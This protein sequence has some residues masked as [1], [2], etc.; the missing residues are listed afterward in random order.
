MGLGMCRR[1]MSDS[2]GCMIERARDAL[3]A[4]LAHA[5]VTATSITPQRIEPRRNGEIYGFDVAVAGAEESALMFVDTSTPSSVHL[6]ER[7][8]EIT[9][10]DSGQRHRAW[11]YPFDPDL[12]ALPAAAVGDA[13][14]VLLERLGL[15]TGDVELQM[16]SY[17]PGRRAVV[18]VRTP[19]G[20]TYYLKVVRPSQIDLLG[21][22]HRDF[23]AASVPV[24][25]IIGWSPDGLILLGELSGEPV[26]HHM[27]AVAG[28]GEFET[29]LAS[30][31]AQISRV[32]TEIRA[33]AGSVERLTWYRD[34]VQASLP[35]EAEAVAR[36]SDEIAARLPQTTG[37]LTRHGDLH[38]DQIM[39]DP[40][41]PTRIT[42]L[43]DI[44][45]SGLAR[46]DTDPSFM[47]ADLLVRMARSLSDDDEPGAQ[48]AHE[49]A[50]SLREALA[51]DPAIT[52]AQL[53]AH[54]LGPAV[55][56]GRRQHRL[57]QAILSAARDVLD[58][59]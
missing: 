11:T 27:E 20:P 6:A 47:Y 49:L 1:G 39:V 58:S 53:V 16:M 51:I 25:E 28:S 13:A 3:E 42:G 35:D 12:P 29:S 48:Q 21:T 24:P 36:I 32:P 7:V 37:T 34:M 2:L 54:A 18:R 26:S 14:Q 59:R 19:G 8:T 41:H 57:A 55:Q 31:I 9:D 43:L 40:A 30:L 5:Q 56:G 33:K 23:L 10:P 52:A 50:T 4:V 44:D 17:R 45:T 15:A 22:I 46:H 38:V